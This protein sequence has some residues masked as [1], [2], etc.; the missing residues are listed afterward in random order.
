MQLLF[1]GAQG[2]LLGAVCTSCL[3]LLVRSFVLQFSDVQFSGFYTKTP[4]SEQSKGRCETQN[5]LTSMVGV[6]FFFSSL[7]GQEKPL[8]SSH[9]CPKLWCWSSQ[10][11]GAPAPPAA[12]EGP[13]S[14]PCCGVSP[15][16]SPE[17]SALVSGCPCPAPC[18]PQ[19]PGHRESPVPR[20]FGPLSGMWWQP[21]EQVGAGNW[22]SV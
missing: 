18:S 1:P 6:I 5:P 4:C 10:A 11:Q 3:C 2:L 7:S 9:L 19:S 12:L 14:C 15:Q 20:A 8:N 22:G 16:L 21:R 17:G 13:W